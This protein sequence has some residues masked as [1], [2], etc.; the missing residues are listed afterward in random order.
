LRRDVQAKVR[1]G[2]TLLD[3]ERS[4]P[5]LIEAGDAYEANHP[6]AVWW[7]ID[8]AESIA[9][10]AAELGA[11][12]QAAR[13]LTRIVALT[14]SSDD[15]DM[16]PARALA[17]AE[18]ALLSAGGVSDLFGEVIARTEGQHG[19]GDQLARDGVSALRAGDLRRAIACLESSVALYTEVDWSPSYAFRRA[20]APLLLAEALRGRP[21]D[22]ARRQ[23]LVDE[24]RRFY[25][26]TGAPIYIARARALQ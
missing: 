18:L 23:Q 22:A 14:S 26:A 19:W 11:T 8:T 17:T 9:F 12:D 2:L 4:L 16:E 13:E 7:R 3:P 20:R 24:V 6:D 5:I 25:E 15:A 10:R 21:A 1:Y